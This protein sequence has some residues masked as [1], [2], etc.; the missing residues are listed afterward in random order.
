MAEA[1]ELQRA[2][3]ARVV[4]RDDLGSV[5]LV[6][7]A[8]VS[9]ERRGDR[10]YAAVTVLDPQTLEVVEIGRAAGS[11]SFPYVPGYLSFRE[12]P[13]VLEAFSHLRRRPDL[14]VCDAQGRL[15]GE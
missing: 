12:L 4:A 9:A 13:L 5:R 7:G 2:L 14:V 11:A 15:F 1:G 8:D 3:A 10:L 6:A